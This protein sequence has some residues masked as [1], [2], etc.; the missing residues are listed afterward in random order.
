MSPNP[1]HKQAFDD[2]EAAL[3]QILPRHR[4]LAPDAPLGDLRDVVAEDP[5]Y[6]RALMQLADDL[7]QADG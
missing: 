4:M 1:E 2:F 7:M 5:A 3:L 6:Q